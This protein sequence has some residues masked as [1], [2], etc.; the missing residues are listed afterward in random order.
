MNVHKNAGLTPRGREILISR[1]ERGERPMDVAAAMGISASTVYKWRRRYRT[2]GLAG[3]RDRSSRPNA[4]PARTPGDVEAKVIALRRER[5]IYSRIAVETGVS[6]A[7]VGRILTRHGLNRWR[8]LPSAAA[9]AYVNH[10]RGVGI[11]NGRLI[12]SGIY[13]W[14]VADFGGGVEG[15][16]DHLRCYAEADLKAR[17]R[18]IIGIAGD[19]YG[20]ALNEAR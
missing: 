18:G 7:T 2:E 3:P 4:G 15:V 16:L 8:D 1:L 5:R 11:D 17:L 9:R 12:V 13:D 19:V 6:R 20:W 14:Y 10:R